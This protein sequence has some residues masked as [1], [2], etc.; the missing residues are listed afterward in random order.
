MAHI[1]SFWFRLH[2]GFNNQC[3]TQDFDPKCLLQFL[4]H[5]KLKL[6]LDYYHFLYWCFKGCR[7]DLRILMKWQWARLFVCMN[8]HIT[9]TDCL[10]Q[11]RFLWIFNFFKIVSYNYITPTC[12]FVADFKVGSLSHFLNR[13]MEQCFVR[14][15][16]NT[17]CILVEKHIVWSQ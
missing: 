9:A 16:S 13:K 15:N 7:M 2:V 5:L 8:P 12:H 14:I 6:S 17:R 3:G 10:L 1:A 4:S 11:K